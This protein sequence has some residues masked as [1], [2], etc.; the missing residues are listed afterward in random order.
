MAATRLRAKP[1]ARRSMALLLAVEEAWRSSPMS[2]SS[3]KGKH[4]FAQMG[5]FSP[6][7]GSFTRAV[8]VIA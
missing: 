6:T 3:R 1:L 4:S 2:Y 8:S 7:F 5:S